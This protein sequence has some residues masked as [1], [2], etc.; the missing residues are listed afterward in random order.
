MPKK[1]R[2]PWIKLWCDNLL[3]GTTVKELEPAECWVFVSYLAMAGSSPE[4]GTLCIAP[5][6]PYTPAQRAQ[7]AH[8]DVATLKSAEQKMLK[9]GKINIEGDTVTVVNFSQYQTDF[10]RDQYM[11]DYMRDYMRQKRLPHPEPFPA[12]SSKQ[13]STPTVLQ[14]GQ[15]AP[16][17][18]TRIIT[19]FA[20]SYEK[21]IGLVSPLIASELADFAV[22]YHTRDAPLSWIGEAFAEA[23]THNKRSWAYVKA[24]LTTWLDQGRAPAENQAD[25]EVEKEWIEKKK[26]HKENSAE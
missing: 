9:H 12:P 20:A 10:D 1:Y 8:V 2:R 6:V 26:R 3:Y 15:G 25:K 11:R 21:E 4:A 7:V 5:G 19:A 16:D 24:I 22:S 18:I 13:P 14:P 17:A 23:A